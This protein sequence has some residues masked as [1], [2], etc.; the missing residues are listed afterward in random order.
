M[1]RKTDGVARYELPGGGYFD[2]ITIS[3]PETY[4]TVN[5]ATS[6]LRWLD[7]KLQQQWMITKYRNEMI[8]APEVSYEWRDVP[9][10]GEVKQ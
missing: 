4:S 8:D 1:I 9:Q 6:G 7:G 3:F 5:Q 2:G 10:D